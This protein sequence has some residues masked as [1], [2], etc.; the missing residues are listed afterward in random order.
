VERLAADPVAWP[1]R[2]ADPRDREI[3][4]FYAAWMAFGRVDLFRPVLA[5]WFA[6]MD[7]G[8][9]PRA[10]TLEIGDTTPID[11]L[12]YRWV[13]ARHLIIAML[14]TGDLV[15]ERGALEPWFTGATQKERLIAGVSAWRAR[16]EFHARQAGF[17]D[18]LPRPLDHLLA[19]PRGT[20][21]CKRWNLALRWLVRP[22]DGV[23]L[24]VWTSVHPR[25]LIMPVDTHV[26]R[27]AR[28]V[29]LTEREDG[30]W[31]T[32][33][34]ITEALRVLDPEDPTRFDFA[35]AHLGISGACRGYRDPAVCAGCPLDPIC[36]A[37]SGDKS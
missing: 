4:A 31:K 25:E 5:R 33:E 11:D 30:T 16:A 18:R 37:P 28:F 15:R 12:Y 32:A 3:A 17:G 13:R 8:G 10:R 22:D 27:I 24:G 2:Y 19:S 7:E 21:A 34:Q 29:G 9:G 14:A 36:R 26:S 1:R 35:L 6:W 23:D 20:S